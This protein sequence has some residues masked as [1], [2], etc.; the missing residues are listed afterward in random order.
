MHGVHGDQ[1]SVVHVV[2]NACALIMCTDHVHMGRGTC[3]SDG[4]HAGCTRQPA[5][6]AREL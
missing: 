4:A 2:N 6:C 1:C 5:L 3:S